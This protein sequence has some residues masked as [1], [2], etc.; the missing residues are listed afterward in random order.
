MHAK[1]IP[2]NCKARRRTKTWEFHWNPLQLEFFFPPGWQRCQCRR[3]PE[4]PRSWW[5]DPGTCRGNRWDRWWS[6]PGQGTEHYRSQEFKF[7]FF[8]KQDWVLPDLLLVHAE[9]ALAA[10]L[11]VR[12]AARVRHG[13]F[14]LRKGGVRPVL[15][16]LS[17]AA[18][19]LSREEQ[20]SQY[21]ISLDLNLTYCYFIYRCCL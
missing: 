19:Q 9:D 5:L 21:H 10:V 14:G 16:L 7:L 2:M 15:V 8:G 6:V 11:N 3:L 4:W 12:K 17:T 13:L 18:L 1:M 20:T